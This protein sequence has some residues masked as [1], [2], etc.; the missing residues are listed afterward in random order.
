MLLLVD[1]YNVTMGDPALSE[2]SK[3]GQRQALV[4]SLKAAAPSLAPRGTVVVVFDA[5]SELGVSGEDFGGVRAVYAPDADTEIVRRCERANEAVVVVTDDMRLRARI[6]Q[7]VSRRVEFKAT[8]ELFSAAARKG[9]KRR[10]SQVAR[11]EGLPPGAKDI[12]AELEKL[13]VDDGED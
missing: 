4:A 13:W 8:A 6:A 9:G 3:E 7:D 11:E 2:L 5:R 10:G 12:T 1:G